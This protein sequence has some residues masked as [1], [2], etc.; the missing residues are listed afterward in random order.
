MTDNGDFMLLLPR[1][2]EFNKRIPKQKFYENIQV[3][4]AVKRIFVEQIKVIYWRSKISAE[5]VNIAPGKNVTEVEI[6]EI[7]MSGISH[8]EAV[9]RQIDSEI[10][11]HIVFLLEYEGKYQAWT[12]FK[13]A[14]SGN[15][16]F[17]VGNYYHTEWMNE[18][19]LPIRIEGLDLDSVYENLVRMI[20]GDALKKETDDETLAESAVRDSKR[21]SLEKQAAAL[22]TKIRKEKQLNK[23]MEMN[24]EL[25]KIIKTLEEL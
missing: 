13:E 14:S 25:K 20:A 24:A 15:T 8:E 6:I 23:Q 12:S 19:E 16:T 11:Y 2:S 9:L 21:T 7:R 10:P 4:P 18:D 1:S 5:T 3:T 17:K 22:K